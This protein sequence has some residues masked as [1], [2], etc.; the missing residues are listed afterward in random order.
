MGLMGW[1]G[2]IH[3]YAR[4]HYDMGWDYFV[5]GVGLA[6]FVSEME[7]Q[8]FTTYEEAFDY[9]AQKTVDR[10]EAMEEARGDCDWD[11]AQA[12]SDALASAGWGTDE[13]YGYFGGED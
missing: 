7:A 8:G 1:Y 13:D 4:K 10:L 12:D 11:D 2:V 6:D 9:Y 3:Q 5:E